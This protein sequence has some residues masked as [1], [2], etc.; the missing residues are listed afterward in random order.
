MKEKFKELLLST[1]RKGVKE[2]LEYLE[3]ETDF[4]SAWASTSFH[5]NYDGGLLEHS[6]NVCEYALRLKDAWD[7]PVSRQSIIICAL[8]HDSG[9]G[10]YYVDNTLKSGKLSGTKPKKIDPS[11]KIKNHA[12]RSVIEVG[13]YIDLTE[14]ERVC[15]LTHDG[16][17][18]STNREYWLDP[19]EL[20]MLIH[21]A[22]LYVARNVEEVK[23]YKKGDT[24]S[25]T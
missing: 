22:D 11:L 21:F 13:G 17:Y 5:C 1:K 16:F 10:N 9:K 19:S 25:D 2:Y 8:T 23:N 14:E 15:I 20:M 3:D 4:F 6:L 18:E 7:S 24:Q 12:L